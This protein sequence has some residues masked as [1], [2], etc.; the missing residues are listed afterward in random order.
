M[1]IASLAPASI[2]AKSCSSY[3]RGSH[4]HT[5]RCIRDMAPG[6]WMS[7]APAPYVR[8]MYVLALR[9]RFMNP[10]PMGS[11]RLRQHYTQSSRLHPRGGSGR[12]SCRRARCSRAIVP[13]CAGRF[14][15][16]VSQ[17]A[18]KCCPGPGSVSE[19]GEPH[20]LKLS[21]GTCGCSCRS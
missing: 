18:R 19:D 8:H 11:C 20:L 15:A 16:G 10:T 3:W 2:F 21:L 1:C 9:L 17:T 14:R 13:I 4:R 6:A 12:R 7:R 5:E